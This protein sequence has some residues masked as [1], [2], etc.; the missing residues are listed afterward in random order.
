MKLCNALAII[1][2]LLALSLIVILSIGPDWSLMK[3]G[4]DNGAPEVQQPPTAA[5]HYA[6]EASVSQET[7]ES[8]IIKLLNIPANAEPLIIGEADMTTPGKHRLVC[9]WGGNNVYEVEVCV[10]D[11]SFT[12]S[13]DNKSIVDGT[14]SLYFEDALATQ[15]FTKG[16]TVKDSLGNV[17]P[18]VKSSDSMSFNNEIG[19]YS[20]F[21]TATDAA[22][23]VF[24]FALDYI[25]TYPFSFNIDNPNVEA[26]VSEKSVIVNIDFDDAPV[27]EIYLWLEDANGKKITGM[28]STIRQK[29]A[30]NGEKLDEY[31]I[32]LR[33]HYYKKFVGQTI[34]LS[35]CS[36][37]GKATFYVTVLDE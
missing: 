10:Y 24:S 12:Y 19:T 15:N 37:Y 11:N 20:V 31:E 8:D 33:A 22:G 16:I 23:H 1:V 30:E 7:V 21:Y 34:E 36:E 6:V 26:R 29:E 17:I 35:I 5:L 18:A 32:V 2:I 28:Y 13:V 14:V 9:A 3:N 27:D 25:V 4:G